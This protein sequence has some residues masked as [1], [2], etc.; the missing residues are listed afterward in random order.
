MPD[1][2]FFPPPPTAIQAI[3][4]I[5]GARVVPGILSFQD[6]PDAAR[7]PEEAGAILMLHA[8]FVDQERANAFWER[9][10]TLMA[11]LENAPGFMRRFS[12]GDGLSM[13]LFALWHT[14]EDA[15]AFSASSEHRAAVRDLYRERWQYS[16][17]SAL[18]EMGSSHDR[19]VFCDECDAITPVRE[20][21][22]GGCGVGLK[23]V[24]AAPATA[25]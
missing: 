4:A 13:Y 7:G 25:S 11:L 9:A 17:F 3:T 10:A 12:F 14:V 16:H 21:I 18:W 22:C 20:G 5:P 24:F 1:L 15:E 23:N 6:G 19:I 2:Q 8:T